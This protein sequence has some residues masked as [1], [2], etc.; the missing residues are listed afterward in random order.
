MCAFSSRRV[1]LRV[2]EPRITGMEREF[3]YD[4]AREGVITRILIAPAI[5]M[6]SDAVVVVAGKEVSSCRNGYLVR[7]GVVGGHT[8]TGVVGPADFFLIRGM[9]VM[10]SSLGSI[11]TPDRMSKSYRI[12]PVGPPMRRMI[13]ESSG[14]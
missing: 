2:S 12:G 5:G 4:L 6:S 3:L 9:A 13:S 10:T 7:Q 14:H 8:S 11:T 1:E